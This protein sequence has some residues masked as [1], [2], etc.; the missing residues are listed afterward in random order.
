MKAYYEFLHSLKTFDRS[1]SFLLKNF[2]QD[3]ISECLELGFIRQVDEES[4]GSVYGLGQ[5]GREYC[6][7]AEKCN[8]Q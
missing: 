5:A 7:W 6:E 3:E 2:S 4:G 8:G 1:R